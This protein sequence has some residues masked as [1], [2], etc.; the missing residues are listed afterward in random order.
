MNT[1]FLFCEVFVLINSLSYETLIAYLFIFILAII[2]IAILA[3]PMKWLFK[4]LLSSIIGALGL[5]L[6]NFVGQFFSFS[7]GINPASILTIGIF[8]IPGFILLIFLKLYLV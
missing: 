3:K 7:I 1:Y 2:F 4:I 8:G 5:Y 6:L